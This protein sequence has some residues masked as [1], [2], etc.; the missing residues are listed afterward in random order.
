MLQCHNCGDCF[1]IKL[2]L[3]SLISGQRDE[4]FFTPKPNT[5]E[6]SPSVYRHRTYGSDIVTGTIQSASF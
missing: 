6:V 2:Y 4:K 5:A 3:I 1:I